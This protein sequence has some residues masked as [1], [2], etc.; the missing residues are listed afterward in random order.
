MKNIRR[1]QRSIIVGFLTLN[2]FAYAQINQFTTNDKLALV[3][4]TLALS[5]LLVLLFS[6]RKTTKSKISINV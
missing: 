5:T 3:I 4:A 2:A 6:K 1:F